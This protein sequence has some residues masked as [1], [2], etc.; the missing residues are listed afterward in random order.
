MGG[1]W[2]WVGLHQ[3]ADSGGMCCRRVSL[4]EALSKPAVRVVL[5]P[6]CMLSDV[7]S[8]GF[9]GRIMHPS[10]LYKR[11]RR[12]LV[13]ARKRTSSSVFVP[14]R[15][16]ALRLP[17]GS[18][19]DQFIY[20]YVGDVVSHPS[21]MKRMRDYAAEG[22][23]HFYFMMLQKDEVIILPRCPLPLPS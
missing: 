2:P 4:S 10:R 13:F 5:L 18:S 20:E 22:L 11:R 3:Q 17:P 23:K 12:A 14:N 15:C 16:M 6:L 9:S 21:F 8:P 1:M 19:R 7:P